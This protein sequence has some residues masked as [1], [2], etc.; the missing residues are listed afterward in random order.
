MT[1]TTSRSDSPHLALQP[2]AD[3]SVSFLA[4]LKENHLVSSSLY[5]ILNSGLQAGAGLVFWI[6]STHV[7][8]VSDVGLATSLVSAALVI[9]FVAILGLNSTMVRYLPGARNRSERNERS[10]LI[11]SSLLI[12]G[13][14][15]GVIAAGYV[16]LIP[17]ISPKLDFVT[18]NTLRTVAFIVLA[19]AGALNLLTD[20][21]FIGLR[22]AR[23]N[24]LID[25]GFG[26]VTKLVSAVVVA[27]SGAF[28]LFFASSIGYTVAALC[29]LV[30]LALDPH[31]RPVVRGTGNVLKRLVR[32]SGANYIG[33]LLALLPAWVVPLIVLD[34]IGVHSTAY[35][36]IAY[37]IVALLYAAVFA[38]EQSFLAEGSHDDA[39]LRR[40]MRRSWRLLALLCVPATLVLTV[41]AH[42]LLLVFG[43]SYSARGT[44]ILII[45]TLATLPLAV[46]DWLLTVLRLTGQLSAIITSN[47]V[48]AVSTCGLAW[49]L[50]PHGIS[51][52]ALASPLGL[53]AASLT[54]AIPA[55]RWARRHPA[56][57]SRA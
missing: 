56:E 9:G 17:V 18:H 54:A 49:V 30:F 47:V 22:K 48:F 1:S 44:W 46:F 23:Y 41:S 57:A 25:G 39:N 3:T 45:L 29:S 15:A 38:V 37:Q 11:T 12:V 35:Y 42:W 13:A 33:N 28:G 7:F 21:I 34:R 27:G 40:T 26:G 52:M 16:F 51:V 19:S 14:L 24:T 6:I 10:V 2:D 53:V 32:F 55:L 8:S 5:L 31:F 43:G 50:A 36:Y 20:A 4:R